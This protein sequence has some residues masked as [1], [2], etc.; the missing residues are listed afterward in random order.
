MYISFIYIYNHLYNDS[1]LSIIRHFG[2]YLLYI[3]YKK[4]IME[5]LL[6]L[7]IPILGKIKKIL[8]YFKYFSGH[9][10]K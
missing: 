4:E 6:C 7:K 1:K 10:N 8:N 3:G 9:N 5:K 2:K